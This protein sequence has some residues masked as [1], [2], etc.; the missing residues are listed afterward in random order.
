MTAGRTLKDKAMQDL[1]VTLRP[2]ETLL[3]RSVISTGIYWKSIAICVIAV[4]LLLFVAPQLAVLFFV[5]AGIAF[6]Y[7]YM[8]KHAL[9]LIVT[10]QRVFVRAGIIKVDTVQIRLDRIESVEIQRTIPGQFLSY[11][12]LMVT[13]TGTMIAFIPYMANA[14]AVRDVI[15]DIL[16]KR[17][18]KPTHVIVD[19]VESP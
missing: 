8:I 7:A 6:M 13:G 9:F 1:P 11:A 5:V 4:L 17:E 16:F 10:N 18:E 15:N 14:Q 2:D 19:K 12:T 3:A